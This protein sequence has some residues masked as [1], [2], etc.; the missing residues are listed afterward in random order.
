VRTTFAEY[1][2]HLDGGMVDELLDVFTDD[3]SFMAVDYPPG[4]GG[5]LEKTGRSGLREVYGGLRFGSFRHH[6]T[7]MSISVDSAAE[8]AELS[9]YFATA[10]PY[11]WGGGLY[12]G[13]LVR[14]PDRWRIATWRV[15]ST[16]G[17]RI[18]SEAP[19]YLDQPLAG[20]APHALR[21]GRPVRW[22]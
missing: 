19:P 21:G 6:T 7:N 17:W 22:S 3:V 4:T 16:W 2:H 1:T 10:S 12:Q 20:A 13:T 14:Q 5:T 9:S 15:T 11:G 8:R 18:G